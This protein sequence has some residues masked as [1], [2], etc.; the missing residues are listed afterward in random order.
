MNVFCWFRIKLFNSLLINSRLSIFDWM[1]SSLNSAI[2]LGRFS[3]CFASSSLNAPKLV[4]SSILVAAPRFTIWF[5]IT[6]S[7]LKWSM[8]LLIG[9]FDAISA[10]N[11]S[12]ITLNNSSIFSKNSKPDG[13]KFNWLSLSKCTFILWVS[14]A[15][16]LS[17]SKLSLSVW[18]TFS[19]GSPTVWNKKL[20]LGLCRL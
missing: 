17:N 16:N 11:F 9:L 20:Q 2:F 8:K 12:L 3:I 15:V 18:Y 10:F 14:N 6:F 1:F 13:V 7:F 19:Y 4:I 5:L